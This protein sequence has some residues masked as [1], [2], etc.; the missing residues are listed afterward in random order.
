MIEGHDARDHSEGLA[1]R[2]PLSCRGT[3][4]VLDGIL[5]R[6][7]PIAAVEDCVMLRKS[8]PAKNFDVQYGNVFGHDMS[9]APIARSC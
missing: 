2:D 6:A 4:H 7:M 5:S 3:T 9:F 8:K 1:D